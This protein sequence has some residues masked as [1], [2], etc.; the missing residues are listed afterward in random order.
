MFLFRV[1]AMCQQASK[2]KH[3]GLELFV[4]VIQVCLF[5]PLN[6]SLES[7]PDTPIFG[8]GWVGWGEVSHEKIIDPMN[9]STDQ[10]APSFCLFC[11]RSQPVVR[12]ESFLGKNYEVFGQKNTKDDTIFSW[13]IFRKITWLI[14]LLKYNYNSFKNVCKGCCSVLPKSS[15]D[16]FSC[17][18]GRWLTVPSPELMVRYVIIELDYLIIMRM[19]I[20]WN[21]R[22]QC[23]TI[24]C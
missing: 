15:L 3:T 10:A 12:W 16:S 17:S 22:S 14:L 6:S 20:A 5:A 8:L 2:Q 7:S 23:L 21:I 1:G 18:E 13:A 19:T 9:S 4:Q 24:R 11:G